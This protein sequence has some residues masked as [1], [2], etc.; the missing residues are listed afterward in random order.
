M[1][2]TAAAR[3]LGAACLLASALTAFGV[4]CKTQAAMTEAERAAIV[5]A[6]RQIALDV[7]AG[8][9]DDLKAATVPAVAASFNSIG[10]AAAALTPLMSGATI[11]VDAVY[12][13]EDR[14][15]TRLNSSHALTSRMPSSA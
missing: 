6:A 10:Q 13:L 2:F 5:Q 1:N 15:S 7:Q 3:G 4:S 9:S 14:K 11:T 8:R 12:Q